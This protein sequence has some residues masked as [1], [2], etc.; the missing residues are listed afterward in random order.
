MNSNQNARDTKTTDSTTARPLGAMTENG[1]LAPSN[2]N[3]TRDGIPDTTHF[4]AHPDVVG[5]VRAT[6]RRYGVSSQDMADA[7]A[8]VQADSIEAARA[9][10][11]PRGP[12]Q[13]KAF[14]ATIAARWAIDRLRETAVRDKYYAGLCDDA[15][16]HVAPHPPLGAPRPGAVPHKPLRLDEEGLGFEWERLRLAQE[17]RG[18]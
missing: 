7:I 11:M 12:A 16:A 10:R 2:D 17:R 9:G 1:T 5:Y 14:A 3:A 6:L 13:W 8:E 15:D 18:L 4:V